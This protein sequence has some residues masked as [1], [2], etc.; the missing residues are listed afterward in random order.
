MANKPAN[1]IMKKEGSVVKPLL[2]FHLLESID[3]L[4]VS[5]V[6]VTL[7]L[8]TPRASFVLGIIPT[9]KVGAFWVPFTT[10][11]PFA[12]SGS[13]HVQTFPFKKVK[14]KIVKSFNKTNRWTTY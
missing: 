3:G 6:R 5:P 1:A 2:A 13:F 4:L 14:I 7:Q 10:M 9:E 8:Y 12:V 11:T